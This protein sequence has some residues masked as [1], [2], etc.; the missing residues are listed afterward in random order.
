VNGNKITAYKNDTLHI[1]EK[2]IPI[3]QYCKKEV[4]EFMLA[5]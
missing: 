2:I 4:Q 5:Q 1:K 3:S